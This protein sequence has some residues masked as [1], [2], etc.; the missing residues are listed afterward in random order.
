M[1]TGNYT[2]TD[3]EGDT[4]GTST[5]TWYRAANFDGSDK[6]PIV[7]AT[8]KT[9]TLTVDDKEK[10][11]FFK[12][13]PIALSGEATGVPVISMASPIEVPGP[14]LLATTKIM[15]GLGNTI[16]KAEVGDQI[17]ID[18]SKPMDFNKI[19][20]T[21][22]ITFL[23][24]SPTLIR[25]NSTKVGRF[26]EIRTN[27]GMYTTGPSYPVSS[28]MDFE[29]SP[30]VWSNNNKTLTITLANQSGNASQAAGTLN[31]GT[32]TLYNNTSAIA[33]DGTSSLSSDITTTNTSSF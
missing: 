12:V 31:E 21:F 23:H 8:S 19:G 14:E 28:S 32:L 11:I 4:E 30:G 29:N 27:A 33:A 6:Q 3:I 18:Y 2:Y 10:Y 22:N 20:N 1:L 5:F 15:N 7:G 26:A 24:S 16:G 9:Y 17:I 25:I 13:K